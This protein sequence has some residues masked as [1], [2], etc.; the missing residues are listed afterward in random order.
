[1]P[2]PTWPTTLPQYLL[3][4]GYQ[5]SMP[6][7]LLR[8]QM[9][10]GPPKVRRRFSAAITPVKGKEVMSGDQL[11]DLRNFFLNDLMGGALVFQW[12]D[13]THYEDTDSSSD[14]DTSTDTDT[15]PTSMPTAYFR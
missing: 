6:N 8:T 13:Q 12:T 3:K 4:R 10:A 14:T 5:T 2:T 9:D 7:V 15:L 1:M 11:E